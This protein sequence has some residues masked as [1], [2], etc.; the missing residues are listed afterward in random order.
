MEPPYIYVLV[1]EDNSCSML[2]ESQVEDYA[3]VVEDG[4]ATVLRID[5]QRNVEEMEVEY[6]DDGEYTITWAKVE[7]LVSPS[8][9][10]DA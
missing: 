1:H 6:D 5:N 2:E 4:F 10:N 7:Y 3:D 9:T 8:T